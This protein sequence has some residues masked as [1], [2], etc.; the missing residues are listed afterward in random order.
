MATISK[1]IG[2]WISKNRVISRLGTA[3]LLDKID[4]ELLKIIPSDSKNVLQKNSDIMQL[5]TDLSLAN[6]RKT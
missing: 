1:P 5:T 6:H 2:V 3:S 4:T